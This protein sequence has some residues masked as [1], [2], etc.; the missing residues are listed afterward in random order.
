MKNS[1]GDRSDK[2]SIDC[3]LFAI[4]V[5]GAPYA[6]RLREVFHYFMA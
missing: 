5:P 3:S 6:V 4:F 1:I 2:R